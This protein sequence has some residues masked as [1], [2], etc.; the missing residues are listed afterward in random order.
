MSAARQRRDQAKRLGLK[1]AKAYE[2]LAEAKTDEEVTAAAVVLGAAFNENIQFICNV[3]KDYG[4]LDVRFP[5]T[6]H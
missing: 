2:A 4:G 1:L 5:D 6:K 3:L